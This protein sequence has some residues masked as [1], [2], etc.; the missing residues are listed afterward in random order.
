MAECDP[1]LLLRE[2]PGAGGETEVVLSVLGEGMQY[3][4]RLC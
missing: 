1:A 3:L 4:H 2:F